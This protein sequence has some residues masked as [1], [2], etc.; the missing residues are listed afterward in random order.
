MLDRC[1]GPGFDHGVGHPLLLLY[2]AK[3][4]NCRKNNAFK[5][6]GHYSEWPKVAD[7]MIEATLDAQRYD[8]QLPPALRP[9]AAGATATPERA[10]PRAATTHGPSSPPPWRAYRAATAWRSLCRWW[11]QTAAR[12]GVSCHVVLRV[13][14]ASSPPF[15]IPTYSKATTL[16]YRFSC[17]VNRDMSVLSVIALVPSP[18]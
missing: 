5:G 2:D 3:A 14:R 18:T 7:A 9:S 4:P 10:T 13:D 12:A 16:L 15:C 1:Y 8:S 17:N 6:L 11:A